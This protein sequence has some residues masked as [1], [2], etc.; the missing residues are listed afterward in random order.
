MNYLI[1][2][3]LLLSSSLFGLSMNHS[4]L[5]VH[6]TLVPKLYLMDYKYQE[7]IKNNKITMALVYDKLDYKVALSLKEQ[8]DFKYKDGLNS[9]DLKT[10][11]VLYSDIKNIDANIYY[12]FPTK[13][14][15]IIELIKYAEQNQALTFSYFKDY[16]KYGVMISLNIGHKVKPILNLDAIRSYNIA[17]RPIL[18]KIS[19]IYKK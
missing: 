6:A 17:F 5:K 2:L 13:T 7:K 8:I 11:L 10:E 15:N 19:N 3:F 18:L 9:Y 4:L 14:E 16:L 1:L 12:L